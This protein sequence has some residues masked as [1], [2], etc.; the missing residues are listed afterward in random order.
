MLV[1]RG[2]PFLVITPQVLVPL[3]SQPKACFCLR[4]P[5]LGWLSQYYKCTIAKQNGNEAEWAEL[6]ITLLNQG[7]GELTYGLSLSLVLM[8]L[9]L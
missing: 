2:V 4:S 8:G 6:F 9:H 1:F 7:D 5:A 3:N